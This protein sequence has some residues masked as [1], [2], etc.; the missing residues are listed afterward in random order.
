MNRTIVGQGGTN[1]KSSRSILSSTTSTAIGF[2][3]YS[4]TGSNSGGG[5]GDENDEYTMSTATSTSRKKS[6]KRP[7]PGSE[8]LVETF[9]GQQRSSKPEEPTYTPVSLQSFM[10]T[11]KKYDPKCFWCKWRFGRPDDPLEDPEMAELHDCYV[12]N[13]LHQTLQELAETMCIV[14]KRLFHDPFK[15]TGIEVRLIPPLSTPEQFLEHIE[16][17]GILMETQ[18]E[19]DF[20]KL[21]YL[22]EMISEKIARINDDTNEESM[23]EKNVDQL[24]KT[25]NMKQQTQ[26]RMEQQF[27][28]GGGGGV[29]KGR[30]H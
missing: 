21:A 23:H 30:K 22:T 3:F 19:K 18:L 7:L 1:S 15:D 24:L 16:S 17:H 14:Q 25:I 11:K 6:R 8:G 27:S 28:S 29:G 20:E 4:N 26:A 13:R 10:Q 12:Y 9:S 2:G 5:R